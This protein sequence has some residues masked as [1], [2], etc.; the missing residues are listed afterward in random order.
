[1]VEGIIT[2]EAVRQSTLQ[3]FFIKKAKRGTL[4]QV[5]PETGGFGIF[6]RVYCEA[7]N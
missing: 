4:A 7:I 6:H 3:P 1:M 5:L 2:K